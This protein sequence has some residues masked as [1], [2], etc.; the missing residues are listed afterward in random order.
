MYYPDCGRVNRDSAKFCIACGTPVAG[1]P[2]TALLLP[3]GTVLQARYEVR[4]IL[5]SGGMGSV[6]LA[7]DQ[8]LAWVEGPNGVHYVSE[9]KVEEALCCGEILDLRGNVGGEAG[10]TW[11]ETDVSPSGPRLTQTIPP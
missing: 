7:A 3:P 5:K 4:K 6:Y 11:D 2:G 10:P 9:S 1:T 8:R